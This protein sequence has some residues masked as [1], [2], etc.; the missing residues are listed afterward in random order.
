KSFME[1]ALPYLKAEPESFSLPLYPY[2]SPRRVVLRNGR[3]GLDNGYCRSTMT[4]MYFAGRGP[5]RTAGCK[6]NEVEVPQVV[7]ATLAEAR[8]RL[9]AQPL[10]PAFV[11]KPARPGQ[12]LGIVLDQF[13]KKG[14]LSSYDKVTLVLAKSL[15]GRVPEV[16]GL[17]LTKAREQLVKRGLRVAV[18]PSPYGKKGRVQAQ[19]PPGGVA[20][21]KHMV[22]KLVVA[23][24]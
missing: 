12:R 23:R 11:F 8:A 20:A 17:K 22:V 13:P 24:G 2:A 18:A 4:I 16:V 9:E 14:A 5:A 10:T 19:Q 1:K 21:G 3:W 15:Y 7:G 6:P